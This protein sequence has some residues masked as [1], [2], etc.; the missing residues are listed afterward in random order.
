MH[1]STGSS[2]SGGVKY[3]TD[4]GITPLDAATPDSDIAKAYA[5][6]AAAVQTLVCH[7]PLRGQVVADDD[8]LEEVLAAKPAPLR[9]LVGPEG[10]FDEAEVDLLRSSGASFVG[11]AQPVL[12]VETAAAAAA[13][14]VARAWLRHARR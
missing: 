9:I 2:S 10:G 13:A 11:L 3:S 7:P 12:R 5:A 8:A 1:Y 4:A 6:E 14:L